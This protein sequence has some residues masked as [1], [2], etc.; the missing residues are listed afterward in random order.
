[1]PG[2][3][4]PRNAVADTMFRRG[5][6]DGR[7]APEDRMISEISRGNHAFAVAV[8]DGPYDAAALSGVLAHAPASLTQGSCGVSPNSACEHGTFILGLLGARQDSMMPGLCPDCRL[9]HIPLFIDENAPSASVD[10]L[11]IA[12]DKAVTAGA[13]LINL[14]LAVL[15]VESQIN[16]RLAA[17]LD[18]AEARRAVVVVAAG[19]QGRLAMGQLL[20]HRVVI[21]VVAVDA[22]QRLLPESNFGPGIAH[23]GVAALGQVPGYAPGGGT[24]VMSGTSAAAAVATGILAQ[25]WSAHPDIDGATLRSAVANLG[26]RNGSKPPILSREFL[27]TA[28]DDMAPAAIA[29]PRAAEMTSFVSL[30]GGAT[31]AI[32]NG[33]PASTQGAGLVAKP[34]QMVAPA[35]GCGCGAPDG[36]CTCDGG[37][38]L[39]GFVYAIGTIEAEC[40]NAAIEREMQFFAEKYEIDPDLDRDPYTKPAEDRQWQYL[41]LSKKREE[42]RYIARQLRWR[43]TIE[44]FPIFV[45]NPNDP[46]IL[47]ALIDAL[48]RPKPS[49]RNPKSRGGKQQSATEELEA[50]PS[51]SA[52]DIDVVI[53]ITG[54]Q[55]SYGTGV[56]VDHIF[57]IGQKELAP[58]GSTYFSQLADNHGLTDEDRAYNYLIARYEPPLKSSETS[59][60]LL[61]GVSVGASRLGASTDRIMRAIYR[62]RNKEGAE[63]K[64]FVRV[65]VTHEYPMIVTEWRSFL[66]RGDAS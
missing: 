20:S 66:E 31:M 16:P 37:N 9:I 26:P 62:F 25:V 2:F 43:L 60:Y 30:Q 56:L 44:G 34:A 8:I 13:R 21:P 50:D 17:A 36:A 15:G 52:A 1:M 63:K 32:G 47:D 39:S 40:P 45:L 55:T 29:A 24:T 64:Y 3:E 5:S 65:D 57:Q 6:G 18:R 54:Q 49:K 33:Q 28:L 35:G 23:R 22:S 58:D 4:Q 46:S 53:G 11:A 10:E 41:V 61:S 38:G 19:N 42:T 27:S 48:N 51:F 7:I 59:G 12:I 14:S